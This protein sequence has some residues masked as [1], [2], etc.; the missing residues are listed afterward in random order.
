MV[1][2]GDT[3]LSQSLRSRTQSHF[4]LVAMKKLFFFLENVLTA[5]VASKS[6]AVGLKSSLAV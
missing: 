5:D 4:V 1:R 6:H 2:E 3:S